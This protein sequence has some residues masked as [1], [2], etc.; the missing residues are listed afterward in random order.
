M[1]AKKILAF[2][3]A[4]ALVFTNISFTTNVKAD[5]EKMVTIYLKDN[6]KEKWVGNNNAKIQLVDNTHYHEKYWMTEDEEGYWYAVVPET[7]YNL[8]FNRFDSKGTTQWNSWSA[9][10]RDSN[11]TYVV[12]GAEFG[13]WYYEDDT[14][15]FHAGDVIYLDLRDFVNWEKNDAKFY[16]DFGT[17]QNVLMDEKVEDHVYAYIITKNDEGSRK[18]KF[19]RG[20]GENRWNDSVILKAKDFK[21]DKNCV[22]VTG[23]NKQGEVCKYEGS[24]DYFK[25]TDGDGMPDYYEALNGTDKYVTDTDGDGLNDCQE[26]LLVQS[27]AL[28][29]DSLVEGTPDGEVDL[30]E[31]GLTN[32]QEVQ[33]GANVRKADTDED[34]LSDYDEVVTYL[35]NPAK[36][37]TDNDG[38]DDF[39]EIAMSMDPNVADTDGNGTPDGEEYIVQTVNADRYEENLNTDN[40]AQLQSLVVSAKG[41]V[42]RYINVAEYNGEL[43]DE[44]R[45]FVGKV[46]ELSDAD[47]NG[48]SIEFK[49]D[50]NYA[51]KDYTLDGTKTNGLLICYN[52]GT[53]TVPL[54]TTYD[55]TTRTL[56]ADITAAGI[57]FVFDTIR[58]MESMGINSLNIKAADTASSAADI[59]DKINA[60]ADI[61]F[62]MDTTGSMQSSINNVKNNILSFVNEL[63]GENIVANYALVDYRDITCDGKNYTNVK[64]NGIFD[65]FS[66]PETFKTE[67]SKLK[68]AGGGDRKETAID[69][70]EVAR[71]LEYRKTAQKF[72]ILVTDADYKVDN[73]YGIG[74]MDE[75]TNLFV[76]DDINV[77]VISS[78][79]Y[80]K[81]YNGL[82]TQTGGVF[83][84]I[85]GN[86]KDQLSKIADMIKNKTNDGYWVALNGL[87]PKIVKINAKPE[88]GSTVDTDGDTICDIDE[89]GSVEPNAVFSVNSILHMLG[90]TADYSE[91]DI[92]VYNYISNP[93]DVNTDGDGLDDALDNEPR[94]PEVHSFVIYESELNDTDL[95]AFKDSESRRDN[96]SAEVPAAYR[97]AD[98]TQSELLDLDQINRTDYFTASKDALA[99][100]WKYLVTF[101]TFTNNDL[102]DAVLNMTDKF[103]A[104]NGDDY[105][106]DALSTAIAEHENTTAY[107]N[108]VKDC[109]DE[110]LAENG[111]DMKALK[112]DKENRSTLPLVA[113]M[114][115]NDS[116]KNLPVYSE[117]IN[118]LGLNVD[119]LYGNKIE[120]TSFNKNG[121][122]Y[123]YTLHYTMYDIY[124][125]KELS[126]KSFVMSLGY[127]SRFV[128]QHYD[129][130]D[131][132][133]VPYVTYME[134]DK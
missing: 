99:F 111:G 19:F 62:V 14:D 77:S 101:N 5:E 33:A 20:N 115:A 35:T 16:V 59:T 86:F 74:S 41:N 51:V 121:D 95:K 54:A 125:M 13:H 116:T 122:S 8:T 118:G 3:L 85:R 94:N 132:E 78:T 89:L 127:N 114:A 112:Y 105:E 134:F 1:K 110:L 15:V 42:N 72:I 63:K 130:F 76:N 129:A 53:N 37:D 126:E 56:K 39:D 7:A 128:M 38:L 60:Q 30:D 29:A 73:N 107:A 68:V 123:E 36:A 2:F 27:D 6:S 102:R 52:D 83:A 46:I 21:N 61:V 55:K 88:A 57:Y 48:G 11:N 9:G 120:V 124:G 25:D 97:Y 92:P 93:V 17:E 66:N 81:D 117:M 58:F 18:L 12:D 64:K 104:G 109:I 47:I 44:S 80:E 50:S 26:I 98:C 22:K 69:G 40:A 113:K 91:E 65:F 100:S 84:N 67:I 90:L 108:G 131:G 28:K 4:I 70:L 71:R 75:M 87:V 43:K 96:E 10:G 49:L 31:D 133:N 34:G 23:W 45:V 106:N 103:T 82:Y 24:I 119:D 32:A 79:T